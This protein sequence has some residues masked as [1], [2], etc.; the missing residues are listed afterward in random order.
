VRAEAVRAEISYYRRSLQSR[1]PINA[2]WNCANAAGARRSVQVLLLINRMEERDWKGLCPE[3][4]DTGLMGTK[5]SP[6]VHR[7]YIRVDKS[8]QCRFP[9]TWI[10]WREGGGGGLAPTMAK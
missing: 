4:P 8:L 7:Q 3:A 5:P 1:S 2:Q 9:S 6:G 10:G